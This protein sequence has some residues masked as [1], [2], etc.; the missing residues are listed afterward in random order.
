MENPGLKLDVPHWERI[1][2]HP[3]VVAAL[4]S[5][6]CLGL[7]HSA[8][9]GGWRYDDGSHLYFAAL[10]SPWQYFFVPEIMREQSWANFTPWNAFFYEIGLPFFG[11]NPAGHYAHLLLVLWAT[12]VATFF[13]LR[14]WLT[15]LSALMGA[16]LFL[17]MPVTGAIGQ[18][19]MTGHYAYGLFFSV[20]TFYFFARGVRENRIN[21]S[22]LAA[23]FYFLA[24]W[25]KELYVPIIAILIFF[26]ESDWKVRFHH[27][28]PAILVA[29]AYTAYRLVVLEGIGGY[30]K[31]SLV[32]VH[33]ATDILAGFSSNLF[34]SEWAGKL[35]AAYACISA[36]IAISI[37]KQRINLLLLLGSIVVV[38]IPILSL[39][40]RGFVDVVSSRLLFLVS[41]SLAVLLAWLVHLSRFHTLTLI[42]VVVILAFSQQKTTD[43]I[44]RIAKV[45]EEQNHFLIDGRKEDM[46]LPLDFDNL[47]KLDC[48]RKANFVLNRHDSPTLLRDMGE[49]MQLGEKAGASIYQFNDH[50]KCMLP[51]GEDQYR[52]YTD[53]FRSRLAAGAE[54]FLSVSIKIEN[55]GFLK[56]LRWE[57]SGPEGNFDFF[58]REFE[59]MRLPPSGWSIYGL[60]ITVTH[61]M[62]QDFH[63]YVHLTSPEG[64]IARSPL[65]TI[66][67]TITNQVSWSGKSAVDWSLQK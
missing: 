62:K 40:Q 13:L 54:Q 24:C 43:H 39:L 30:G 26:P 22:L 27:L 65:L 15:S 35:I 41:W 25:S 50:C 55:L 46:L 2:T 44:I 18:M 1:L 63:V 33:A 14:L 61:T 31:S 12:S 57:F 23:G 60:D 16:A 48:I 8:L 58:I 45:M 36:L 4:L 28:W 51:I 47:N 37:R 19:L 64:W 17:A 7:H 3:A 56:R 52:N 20:L 21:F 67:P 34:G 66:N 9:S 32:D 10:Y 6:L 38:S 5:L 29:I 49:F 59:K 11:L 53:S 42:V